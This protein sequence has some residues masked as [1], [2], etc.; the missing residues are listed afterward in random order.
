MNQENNKNK[1][2]IIGHTKGIGKAIEDKSK[3]KVVGL[4]RSNG[5]D[6]S[7]SLENILNKLNDCE[8]I[9]INAYAGKNQLE[10]L[11]R[12]Y[13]KYQN[14]NKKVGDVTCG[15]W[16]WKFNQNIGFALISRECKSG[17]N[18]EVLIDGKKTPAILTN[19]PFKHK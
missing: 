19:L 15:I 18:V 6:L 10:L 1:I 5:Y 17:D 16:S 11:K 8:Y 7:G 9:V 13:N 3:L 14:E 2:C 4:S 12:I